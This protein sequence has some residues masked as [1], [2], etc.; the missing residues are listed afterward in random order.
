MGSVFTTVTPHMLSCT[1]FSMEGLCL[2]RPLHGRIYARFSEEY[3]FLEF[4]G[5]VHCTRLLY[6]PQ[7]TYWARELIISYY[8]R[9]P[10]ALIN[11]GFTENL[12]TIK[13]D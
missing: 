4:H 3:V 7:H 10:L 1:V 12:W 13:L 8:A 2:N 11:M 9:H 6:N 5:I